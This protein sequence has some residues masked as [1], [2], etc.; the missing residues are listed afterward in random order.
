MFGAV[1]PDAD[2]AV[3]VTAADAV[4]VAAVAVDADKPLTKRTNNKPVE[5]DLY[6]KSGRM[7]AL[8]FYKFIISRIKP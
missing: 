2:M 5:N 6:K 4:M 1:S 8:L 3:V 7:A